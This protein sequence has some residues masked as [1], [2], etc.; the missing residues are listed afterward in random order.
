MNGSR[1]ARALLGLSLGM[2]LLAAAPAA[3]TEATRASYREAVEPIC[4]VNTK[5]N[6]RILAGVR[7][8]VKRGKLKPAARQLGRAA[9]ALKRTLVELRRVPQPSA[10]RARLGKWLTDIKTEVSLFERIATK[11]RA[12]EKVAA[13]RM[14][15]LLTTNAN[16]ANSLVLVFEF[17]YCRLEPSRFL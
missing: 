15:V 2:L 6:E 10:D 4:K 9:A 17:K 13:E 1:L 5:A 14:V 8:E 16:R 3:A 12:G 11:L 7:T